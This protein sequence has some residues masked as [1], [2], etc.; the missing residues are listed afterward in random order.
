MKH[1]NRLSAT[2]PAN[3]R[4]RINV[5]LVLV[6]SRRRWIHVKP[7]LI[8]RLV[9]ALMEILTHLKLCSAT[10]TRQVNKKY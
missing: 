3:T 5:G 8:Q 1:G 6:Q 10:A 4:R 2:I 7:T 9:S